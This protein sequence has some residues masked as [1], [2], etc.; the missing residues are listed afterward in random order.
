LQPRLPGRPPSSL[1]RWNCSKDPWSASH[2]HLKRGSSFARRLLGRRESFIRAI[3]PCDEDIPTYVAL[4]PYRPADEY[5]TAAQRT[6]EKLYP[7][8]GLPL[9]TRCVNSPHQ[10]HV[11]QQSAVRSLVPRLAQS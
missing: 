5:D 6:P 1:S 4:C 9:A 10:G 7:N 8:A 2:I 11:A 3:G